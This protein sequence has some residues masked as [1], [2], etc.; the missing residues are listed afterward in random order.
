MS[1]TPTTPP[2]QADASAA[3][4]SV[5][6]VDAAAAAPAVEEAAAAS[7]EPKQ[8][9]APR[10]KK[11]KVVPAASPVAAAAASSSSATGGDV[12]SRGRERKITAKFEPTMST[13]KSE[14]TLVIESGSGTPL[15]E[16]ENV[17]RRMDA[18]G[19]QEPEMKA[20]FHACFPEAKTGGTKFVIKK[21]IREFSGYVQP[22]E[23]KSLAAQKL[24][25]KDG[26]TLKLVCQMLDISESG[27]KAKI[28]ESITDFLAS[29]KSSGHAYKHHSSSSSGTK[30]KASS[31]KKKTSKDGKEKRAPTSFII[32]SNEHR[33]KVKADHPEFD[34]KQCAV[35]MG[36]MWRGLSDKKKQHYKDLSAKGKSNASDA[37]GSESGSEEESEGEEEEEVKP[38]KKVK[39]ETKD[40]SK[41]NLSAEWTGKFT[42]SIEAILKSSEL[43][44]LSI[45]KVREQLTKQHGELVVEANKDDIKKLILSLI[46]KATSAKA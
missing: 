36:E 46:S 9:K 22:K 27:T 18:T 42:K 13:K 4:P 28:I 30:R 1:S 29:P 35:K 20:L 14:S 38:K 7:S 15:G 34:M 2:P 6:P 16:I 32:F 24:E 5:A 17:K 23:Q 31:S 19:A 40:E 39:S 12:S 45:A 43:S 10:A 21:N 26:A 37:S 3:A 11:E 41:S 25:T 44:D 8:K 33:A